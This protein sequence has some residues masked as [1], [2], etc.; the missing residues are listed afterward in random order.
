MSLKYW[1]NFTLLLGLPVLAQGMTAQVEDEEDGGGGD[2]LPHVNITF[3]DSNGDDILTWRFH[4]RSF[5]EDYH[6]DVVELP[7]IKGWILVWRDPE[8]G[9]P[10]EMEMTIGKTTNILKNMDKLDDAAIMAGFAGFFEK[11][12]LTMGYDFLS[13]VHDALA[14]LGRPEREYHI[15]LMN[16][17][18]SM[19]AAVLAYPTD[20]ATDLFNFLS[21]LDSAHLI[22]LQP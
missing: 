2:T 10:F 14:Q 16:A 11:F 21:E 20:D 13:S 19:V 17:V 18:D 4:P 22:P 12:Y 15:H 6:L 8:N 7:E 5:A 9:T 1:I 3:S